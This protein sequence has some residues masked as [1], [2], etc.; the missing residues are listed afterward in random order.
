M[1]FS[2]SAKMLDSI[3]ST[4]AIGSVSNVSADLS[5]PEGQDITELLN[6]YE[7][8]TN[9]KNQEKGQKVLID[10]EEPEDPEEEDQD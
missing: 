9:K 3:L 2:N 4:K 1:E 5:L 8:E 7:K 10:Q 6:Q